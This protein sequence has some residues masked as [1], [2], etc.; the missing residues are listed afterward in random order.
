MS[1]T[2]ADFSVGDHVTFGRR[3]GRKAHGVVVKVNPAR[4][5]V[6]LTKQWNSHAPGGIWSVPPSCMQHDKKEKQ[7]RTKHPIMDS[8]IGQK[9]MVERRLTS[10]EMAAIGW[11]GRGAGAL[12]LSNGHVIVAMGDE[13]GNM[14]G[15]MIKVEPNGK[16]TYLAI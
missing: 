6:Q 13:E 16:T 12:E 1:K 3:N 10:K 2:V 14:P 4:V 9:I 5:K 15:Q 11:S 7:K 8:L